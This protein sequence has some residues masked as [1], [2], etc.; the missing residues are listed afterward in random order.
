MHPV[1]QYCWV[2]KNYLIVSLVLLV[3]GCAQLD[4]KGLTKFEPYKS[5]NG[6]Q[7]FKYFAHSTLFNP[8]DS[9]SGEDDRMLWLQMWLDDNSMCK[10]GYEILERKEVDVGLHKAIK[11]IYYTGRCK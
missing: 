2:M 1:N 7:Q 11:D 10:N 4:K 6:D 3:C 5:S 8:A 9:K